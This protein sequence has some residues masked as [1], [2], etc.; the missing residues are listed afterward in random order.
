MGTLGLGSHFFFHFL[1]ILSD[2]HY[3]TCVLR[4]VIPLFLFFSGASVM[5]VFERIPL[6]RQTS[7]FAG[8]FAGKEAPSPATHGSISMRHLQTN[9]VQ[10]N[11][12]P[13]PESKGLGSSEKTQDSHP[14][15]RCQPPFGKGCE[16][17][18]GV[19]GTTEKPLFLFTFDDGPS[20]DYTPEILNLL[21]E[22]GVKALFF[23]VGSNFAEQTPWALRRRE[24]LKDIVSRGH[25]LGNHS[26]SHKQLPLLSG[27]E[28]MQEVSRVDDVLIEIF[29]ERSVLM[30]PPGGSVSPRIDAWLTERGYT[31][32]LWNILTGDAEVD[33]ASK[34]F[35]VFN[36]LM[37]KK[38][39]SGGIVLLHDTHA[40][41]V[42]GARMILE[43]F[44]AENCRR[45]KSG[46]VLL[47]IVSEITPFVY[48]MSETEFESRQ[49][50]LGEALLQ[51]CASPVP[52]DPLFER[53][54]SILK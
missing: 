26:M 35:R 16:G 12:V 32:V 8:K 37:E 30:R 54:A 27:D 15:I 29:G 7:F 24:I 21:D 38:D 40:W 11:G 48:P 14:A 34:M 23:V 42:E 22:Y 52:K 13:A 5:G 43:W 17:Q 33:T 45:L 49:I 4:Y 51:V 19:L 2:Q 50:A 36:R 1:L 46:E 41:S 28:L 9:G 53:S 31:S 39:G 47:D 18:P 44:R 20:P 25:T 3:A 6:Q 10:T